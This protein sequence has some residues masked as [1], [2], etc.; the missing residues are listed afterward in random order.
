M[1]SPPHHPPAL[2]FLRTAARSC[3]WCLCE[4]LGKWQY[5][6][7]CDAGPDLLVLSTWLRTGPQPVSSLVIPSFRPSGL[8]ASADPILPSSTFVPSPPSKPQHTLVRA[9]THTHTHALC[10]GVITLRTPNS[11]CLFLG[12]IAFKARI[13]T[14]N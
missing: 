4:A 1:E 13:K 5:L 12:I 7:C 6:G 11:V 2:L 9:C 14:L 8:A 10:N 3:L